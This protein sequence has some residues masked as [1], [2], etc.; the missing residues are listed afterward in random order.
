MAD[1]R[2]EHIELWGWILAG[3]ASFFGAC[4][5]LLH[6]RKKQ[7]TFSE[8]MIAKIQ[9][10]V[11]AEIRKE[12]RREVHDATG[13]LGLQLAAGVMQMKQGVSRIEELVADVPWI[14]DEVS[15]Q[16]VKIRGLEA[17]ITEIRGELRRARER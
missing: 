2:Q 1:A 8:E 11:L 17:D 12:V 6:R 14:K 5:A 3:A 15:Q 9:A 4:R 7:P 13:D 16:G 10:N